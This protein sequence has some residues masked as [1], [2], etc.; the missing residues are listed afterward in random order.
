MLGIIDL[1]S[2]SARS[3]EWVTVLVDASIKGMAVLLVAVLLRIA[4]RRAP[5]S[6]RYLVWCLALGS[7]V[8]LP[9]VSVIY[10]VWNLP[11]L[12][13]VE[14]DEKS[15]AFIRDTLKDY[16]IDLPV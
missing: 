13:Q 14:P 7:V 4:L 5:A 10:P 6:A 9:L 11:I 15:A 2:L 8:A 1:S 16:Q 3:M 12:P